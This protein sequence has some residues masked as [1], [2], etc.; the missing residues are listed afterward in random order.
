MSRLEKEIKAE[1]SEKV[2]SRRKISQSDIQGMLVEGEEILCEGRIHWAIYWRSFAVLILGALVFM[3]VSQ[4]G[5]LL[6]FSG[7]AML[8]HA[9]LKKEILF[10][11]LTNKRVLFRYGILQ[12]DVVDMRFSKIE[13]V[14]LERMPPGY[15]LGY[16]N[17]VMMGTGNRY[18]V[19]P[20]VENAVEFRR[21][22]N[23][24]TLEKE[25]D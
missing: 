5:A 7:L 23:R 20:Y 15:I 6:L 16:A 2:K 18:I 17:V 25:D 11:V 14:E 1:E 10:L 19:I 9:K 12:V 3:Y 22:Y 13:S 4:I 21:E 24:I 8:V